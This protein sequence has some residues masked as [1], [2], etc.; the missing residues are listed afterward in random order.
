[1]GNGN[2][3]GHVIPESDA[4]GDDNALKTMRQNIT[5][6]FTTETQKLKRKDTGGTDGEDADERYGISR[7]LFNTT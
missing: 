7:S 5:R 6:R 4:E 2:H 3:E 1:M